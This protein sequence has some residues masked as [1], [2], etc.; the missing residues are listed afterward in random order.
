MERGKE[1]AIAGCV[2]EGGEGRGVF[3]FVRERGCLC[4]REFEG[5]SHC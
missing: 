3:V 1:R 4:V 2:C 5:S